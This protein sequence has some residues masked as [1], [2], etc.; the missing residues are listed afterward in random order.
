[1]YNGSVFFS[2]SLNHFE[3]WQCRRLSL[4]FSHF[5]RCRRRC[6]C[7]WWCRLDL[8]QDNPPNRIAIASCL[9]QWQPLGVHHSICKW[10]RCSCSQLPY[11]IW[12]SWWWWCAIATSTTILVARQTVKKKK[13]IMTPREEERVIQRRE[14][15]HATHIHGHTDVASAHAYMIGRIR[16]QNNAMCWI[17]W[18][19]HWRTP[20]KKRNKKMKIK[21]GEELFWMWSKRWHRVEIK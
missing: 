20:N 18:Q 16:I 21:L 6:C 7:G 15:T 9:Q 10:H 3:C 13:K 2:P 14:L 4:C 11:A 17:N 5:C 12:W 19:Q 8:P 1:M